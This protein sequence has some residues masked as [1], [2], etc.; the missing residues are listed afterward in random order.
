MSWEREFHHVDLD[1][2][3]HVISL[4]DRS[5]STVA[6]EPTRYVIQ[7]QL[8]DGEFDYSVGKHKLRISLGGG[9]TVNSDGTYQGEDGQVFDPREIEKTM[10]GRL[11]NYHAALRTAAK[12]HGAPEYKGPGKAGK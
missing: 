8:G 4:V 9:I 2:S 12:R 6:G 11:N 10:I 7:I 3:E 5:V 1:R